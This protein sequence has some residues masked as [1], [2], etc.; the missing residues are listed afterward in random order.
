MALRLFDPFMDNSS[1]LQTVII[2]LR[3]FL[4]VVKELEISRSLLLLAHLLP[5]LLCPCCSL[6]LDFVVMSCLSFNAERHNW[7]KV[8]SLAIVKGV[9]D[10]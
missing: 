8:H 4:L 1:L 7:D 3:R 10:Y 5:H 2:F 9:S 6:I